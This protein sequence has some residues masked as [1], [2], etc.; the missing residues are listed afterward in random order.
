MSKVKLVSI[1]KQI[2]KIKQELM[3]I[4]EM[5]PGSLTKQFKNRKDQTG[6]FYQISYTSKMKSKT[7]YVRPQHVED[8]QNQIESYKKFKKLIGKWVALSIEHSKLKMETSNKKA[9]K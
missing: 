1:E 6:A 2:K 9:Q 4:T 5:R 3:T 8:L 7:E